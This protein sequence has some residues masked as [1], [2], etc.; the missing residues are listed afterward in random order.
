V[1]AELNRGQ[2]WVEVDQDVVWKEVS[3]SLE[4][5][6]EAVSGDLEQLKNKIVLVAKGSW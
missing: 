5:A 2:R 3:R 6:D 4:V 1:V